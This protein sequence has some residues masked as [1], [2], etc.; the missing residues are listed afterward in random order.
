MI[1]DLLEDYLC[2][3][4]KQ[5]DLFRSCRSYKQK[6]CKKI[7]KL[8]LGC[9]LRFCIRPTGK[10]ERSF[11][12]LTVISVNFTTSFFSDHFDFINYQLQ[13][14]CKSTLEK[15]NRKNPERYDRQNFYISFDLFFQFQTELYQ[16]NG[17]VFNDQTKSIHQYAYRRQIPL[18][19]RHC[20]A[21]KMR[22]EQ[23]IVM[24]KINNNNWVLLQD[25]K[26]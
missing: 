24:K 25:F 6:K 1:I 10:I 5:S 9:G 2:M 13:M 15:I 4:N 20:F 11:L 18:T 8:V 16:E 19:N 12:I 7:N 14:I 23:R 22:Q 17:N 3:M 21:L 26:V